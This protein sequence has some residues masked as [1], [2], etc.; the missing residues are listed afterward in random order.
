MNKPK[1]GKRLRKCADQASYMHKLLTKANA[2]KQASED[3]PIDTSG[4]LDS[5]TDL[6]ERLAYAIAQYKEY[7]AAVKERARAKA[8]ADAEAIVHSTNPGQEHVNE[9]LFDPPMDKKK[10]IT[11]RAGS[12]GSR[13]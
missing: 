11:L 4:L 10:A 13:K 2:I 12:K 7:K 9:M 6:N 5:V 8:K 3:L 1:F